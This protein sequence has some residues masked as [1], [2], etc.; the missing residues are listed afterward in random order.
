MRVYDP[1]TIP[2]EPVDP[3]NFTGGGT[4]VRMDG[5]CEAPPVN[6]YRVSFAPGTRTAWHTHSGTQLLLVVEGTCRFQA[7][8][9]P[10]QEVGTGGIVSIPPGERHWHGASADAPMVHVALNVDASTTWLEKVTDREYQG[11]FRQAGGV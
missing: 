3:N 6:A 8:G 9:E 5:I 10:V 2:A 4:L 7:D 11:R 1:A